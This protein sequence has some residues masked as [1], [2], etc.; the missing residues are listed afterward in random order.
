ME[1]IQLIYASDMAGA[2]ES[3]LASIVKSAALH[4]RENQVTGMLLYSGG[5]FMQVL[6]GEPSQVLATYER[7]CRDPRHRNI[8]LLLQEPVQQRHFSKWSMGFKRL[9]AEHV[10]K[11]PRFAPYFQ[12]GF[13]VKAIQAAPGVALDMLLGFSKGML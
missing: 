1:L 3:E 2:Q 10:Q 9:S 13:D 7:I 8:L 11:F 5:N 12:Y 4:N 6:E